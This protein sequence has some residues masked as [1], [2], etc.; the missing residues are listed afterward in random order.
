MYQFKR[1]MI[2]RTGKS[3]S[4]GQTVPDNFSTQT[5]LDE[6]VKVGDIE[7][8][9]LKNYTIETVEEI[10][11]EEIQDEEQ[12]EVEPEELDE[13]HQEEK[14]GLTPEEKRAK[15]AARARERRAAKRAG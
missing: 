4:P 2:D 10:E 15:A 7:E 1:V 5:G 13:D 11:P 3:Y 8:V 9:E 6:M 12:E 14:A